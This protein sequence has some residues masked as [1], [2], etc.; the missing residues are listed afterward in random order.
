MYVCLYV[1]VCFFVLNSSC[2]YTLNDVSVI[3]VLVFLFFGRNV[4]EWLEFS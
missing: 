2:V 1:C 3:C 4:N